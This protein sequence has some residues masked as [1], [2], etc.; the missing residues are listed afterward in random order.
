MLPCPDHLLETEL[1]YERGAFIG[2]MQSKPG[3]DSASSRIIARALEAAR[4][5][6]IEVEGFFN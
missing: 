5:A 1:F 2:A 4:N 6:G 3:Y